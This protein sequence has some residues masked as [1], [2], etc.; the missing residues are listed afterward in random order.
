MSNLFNKLSRSYPG[1]TDLFWVR[2]VLLSFLT[3]GLFLLVFLLLRMLDSK[4][5]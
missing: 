2:L 1:Q 3:L 5:N 4:E